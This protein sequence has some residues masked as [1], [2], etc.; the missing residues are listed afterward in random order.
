MNN[1]ENEL[2][3]IPSDPAKMSESETRMRLMNVISAIP[4]FQL[5]GK[6]RKDITSIFERLYSMTDPEFLDKE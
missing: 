3:K 5:I 1:F 6:P 2:N 4:F